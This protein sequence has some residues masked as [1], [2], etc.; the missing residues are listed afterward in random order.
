MMNEEKI[1][2]HFNDKAVLQLYSPDESPFFQLSM[3]QG[4]A[5]F[6]DLLLDKSLTQKAMFSTRLSFSLS[7]LAVGLVTA[8]FG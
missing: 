8:L 4:D 3:P 6:R 7:T 5:V 2:L 1:S